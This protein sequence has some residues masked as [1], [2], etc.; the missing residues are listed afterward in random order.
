MRSL[1]QNPTE[2]ELYEMIE[3]IDTTGSGTIDF[4][5][6]LTMMARKARQDDSE[7]EIRQAFEFFDRDGNGYISVAELQ[8]AMNKLGACF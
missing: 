3:E 2:T 5:E 4:P 8:Y 7:E 1:G 6:F